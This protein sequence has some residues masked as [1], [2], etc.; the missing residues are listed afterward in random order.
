MMKKFALPVLFLLALALCSAGCQTTGG[1]ALLGAG[2]GA[3]AGAI[4]GHN[5]DGVSAGEGALAGAAIGGLLGAQQGR[6]NERI[7][8]LERQANSTVVNVT[9]SNGSVTPV[10]LT[11]YG[12]QWRG[13]RGELYNSLPSGSQLRGAYGF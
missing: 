10:T 11:R 9:N 2:T 6:Q 3:G 7:N 12:N 8:S 5:V 4:I 1:G 13:P